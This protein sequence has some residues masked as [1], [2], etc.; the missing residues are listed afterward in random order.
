MKLIH[1]LTLSEIMNTTIF[2][3]DAHTLS[4]L[5][6]KNKRSKTFKFS[7]FLLSVKR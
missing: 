4:S 3:A 1:N 6:G 2:L 5:G 7:T